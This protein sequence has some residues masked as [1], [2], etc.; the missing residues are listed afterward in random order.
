MNAGEFYDAECRC[1]RECIEEREALRD[2]NAELLDALK[3]VLRDSRLYELSSST[4]FRAQDA[5]AKAKK[6]K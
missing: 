6:L 3:W 2:M 4:I 1:L 5:V